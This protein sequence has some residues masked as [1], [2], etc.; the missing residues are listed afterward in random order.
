MKVFDIKIFVA[1]VMALVDVQPGFAALSSGYYTQQSALR[2]GHW[3]KIKVRESGMHQ[4]T[5][6]ELRAMGF[7]D[8]EKVAVYGYPAVSLSDYRLTSE[9]S[10][11]LPPVTI[12]ARWR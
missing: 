8:P 7:T 12:R 1:F 2:S 6:A 10:D 3:V 5:D 4:I 11:D 9:S